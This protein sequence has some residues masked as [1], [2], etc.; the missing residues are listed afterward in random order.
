MK[1]RLS[2]LLLLSVIAVPACDEAPDDARF[3]ANTFVDTSGTT[4]PYRLFVPHEYTPARQYPLVLFLHGGSGAGNDNTRQISRENHIGSHVWTDAQNQERYPAFVVAP[5]L[6]GMA[7]WDFTGSSEMS[8]FGEATVHLLD[9]LIGDY[10]IDRRRIYVTG[11][12]RG[13]WGVWDLIAKRPDLF[14]AAVPICGGGDPAAIPLARGV[15]VWAFHGARDRT[16][17]VERTREMVNALRDAGGTVEYTE[18]RFSGH[19]IWEMAYNEDG[20]VDWLFAKKKSH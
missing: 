20:L 5:Q 14:A 13:G 7:R 2:A 16:V 4:L 18:F 19:V 8:T 6:P 9:D 17:P 1:H 11:Q 3:L 15:A 10:S 12:S